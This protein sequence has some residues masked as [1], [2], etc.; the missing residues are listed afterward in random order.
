MV[1]K[2]NISEEHLHRPPKKKPPRHDLRKP[3]VLDDEDLEENEKDID[4]ED[5]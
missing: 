5:N 4:L 1:E 2:L 3:R